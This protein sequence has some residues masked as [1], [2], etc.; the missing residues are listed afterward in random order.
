MGFFSFTV[1]TR[2]TFIYSGGEIFTFAGG[3]ELYIFVNKQLVVQ[4]FHDPANKSVPC[5]VLKLRSGELSC[6]IF[7][8]SRR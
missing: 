1:A 2:N 8:N 4:L 6:N 7:L 5:A 3:E